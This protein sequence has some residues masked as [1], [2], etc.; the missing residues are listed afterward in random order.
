MHSDARI[1]VAGHNGLVGSSIVRQ[2]QSKNYKNIITRSHKE[3]DL[4]DQRSVLQFYSEEK[5]EFVI[6]AAAKVG[7]IHANNTYPADFI[8]QN[9]MIEANLIHSAYLNK[10]KKLAFLGSSCI[11]PK[12]AEQPMAEEALL[13]GT[14]EPTNEPYAVA[15]IA[16]IK[17]CSSYNRQYGTNYI[18]LMPTNL[19]GM[20]DNYDLNNSHVI[21]AML[22]KF[23]EGKDSNAS[24]V[25][26][27]GTGSPKREFL[28]SDD[29]A[30][31]CIYLMENKNYSDIGEII[32]IGSGKEITIKELA[33]LIADVVGYEGKIVFDESK[34]DGSPRK[35][36]NVSRLLESGWKPKVD[37]KAGLQIAYDDFLNK[38]IKRD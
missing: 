11:Y 8:Y 15:K 12:H 7:G 3:L 33:I 2:L 20:N 24:E 28:C 13:T 32:N 30:D 38:T 9:I 6:I 25:V 37:F 34:P 19:Y 10:V 16:G 22:R 5:P 27:W 21:P 17:M 14:L 26:I 36:L 29:M 35:L 4:T 18:S 23:H 31:A 1:Y